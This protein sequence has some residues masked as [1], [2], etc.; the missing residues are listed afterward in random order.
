MDLAR[1]M[2]VPA[3]RF[4]SFGEPPAGDK[5]GM[6]SILMTQIPGTPLGM[7][8]DDQVDFEVVRSDLLS[9][10]TSMRRYASPW[11]AAVCGI[12][13]GAVYGPAVPASP[14]A[15]CADEAAF[16][17]ALRGIGYFHETEYAVAIQM[18]ERFFALPRHAIV[19]THGDLNQYNIIIG[20]DG[21]VSGI[22]DWEAAAWLPEYWEVSVTTRFQQN[23]WGRFMDKKVTSGMYEAEISGHRAVF[24]LVSDSFSY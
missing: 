24:A 9:I 19:F 4:I 12:D 8:R 2:G 16:H 17:D 20:G 18:A 22:I 10:F 5:R 1:A 15:A 6:P 23:K 13:G 7:L 3:P 14:L 11:G 21:H